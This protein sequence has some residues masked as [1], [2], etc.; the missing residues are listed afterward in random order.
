MEAEDL[1]DQRQ[2]EPGPPGGPGLRIS[3][4]EESLAE[5]GQL[6][7]GDARAVVGHGEHRRFTFDPAR[8][9]DVAGHRGVLHRVRQ[10]VLED[11]LEEDRIRLD[12]QAPSYLDGEVVARR[13]RSEPRDQ[14]FDDRPDVDVLGAHVQAAGFEAR[15]IQ[16]AGDDGLERLRVGVEASQE[17]EPHLFVQDAPLPLQRESHP[18]D[19][20][21]WGP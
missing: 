7:L 21:E 18:A 12:R 13:E 11:P 4:T 16:E 15:E 2:A 20:G 3:A 10:Q 1:R 9:A 17:L 19:H 5:V 8:D 14:R 6:L